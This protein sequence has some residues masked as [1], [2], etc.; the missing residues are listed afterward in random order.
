M[1]IGSLF[2]LV[3]LICGVNYRLVK[4]RLTLTPELDGP[5]V[6]S[7]ATLANA[8]DDAVFKQ[9]IV[10]Q[11]EMVCQEVLISP[12]AERE[13]IAFEATIQQEWEEAAAPGQK[14][15]RHTEVL[16]QETD[17]LPFWLNDG[18]GQILVNPHQAEIVYIEVL[19]LF[20]PA[21]A[22]TS[23][24]QIGGFTLPPYE[25]PQPTSRRLV[26]Y[27]F[28]EKIFPREG[29]LYVQGQAICQS[30]TLQIQNGPDMNRPFLISHQ[31]E[32]IVDTDDRL[33]GPVFQRIGWLSLVMGLGMCVVGWF[34]F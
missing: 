15:Q 14:G 22:R 6:S 25:Q 18:T 24:L 9:D 32:P 20:E 26:G 2:L 8:A 28:S 27:H 3:A 1:L 11:G 21:R 7:L 31:S 17:R 4:Q 10:L 34:G 13:C 23:P 16:S 29:Y 19:H 30:G 5:T 12:L 33:N